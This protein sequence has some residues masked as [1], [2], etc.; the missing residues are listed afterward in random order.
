MKKRTLSLLLAFVMMLSLLPMGVFAASPSA[1]A[2]GVTVTI[3]KA[4]YKQGEKIYYGWSGVDGRYEEVSGV[5]W[6]T[7]VMCA[8]GSEHGDYI[9]NAY[10]D[11]ESAEINYDSPLY[12][13]APTT[14]GNY[15]IRFYWSA[16]CYGEYYVLSVP[17]TVGNVKTGNISVAQT[18]HTA[19]SD[20][21]VNYSGITEEMENASAFVG[22]F[23]SNAKHNVHEAADDDYVHV[24]AGAGQ[25][26][27]HAPNING[28]FEL[29]LYN[30]LYNL[31]EDNLVMSV[32]VTLTGATA[33]EWAIAELEKAEEL[34]LIPESLVGADLTKP[35]TRAEFAAVSVKTYEAIAGVKAK[36]PTV[37]N[38]FKDT[39]DKEVLKAYEIG[40]TTGTGD[41][42]TFSPNDLLNRE[43]AATMLTRVYKKTSMDGWTMAKDGEF[44]LEYTKP[45][46]FSDDANISGWAK[47]SVYF[48][49]ANKII[50]GSEGK[51]MPK[52]TTD[53]EIAIGY[54]QATREQALLIAVRMVENLK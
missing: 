46:P 5:L 24:K 29:R 18:E 19:N 39:T 10:T 2:Q 49:A 22:I 9:D 44:V 11:Y 43:Q 40:I 27:V 6:G 23:K 34:G 28:Q 53:A 47:D 32:P 25:I 37:E 54:A 16:Y 45:A 51:F 15:E 7:L 38:P 30:T 21:M 42:T 48:M 36:D 17:F 26:A 50:Q 33:S 20:I 52:A 13:T 3:D 8:A 35:I 14:D 1:T 31:T 12:F 4:N 41:G